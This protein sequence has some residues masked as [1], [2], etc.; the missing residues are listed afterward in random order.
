[1]RI[2]GIHDG[3][4]AAAALVVDGRVVAAVQEER[5]TREKNWSGFPVQSIAW[6]L[7][8]AGLEARELDAVAMNGTHMPYPKDRDALLEEYRTTGTVATRI[9]RIARR[10][11]LGDVYRR[12][13]RA[14]RL[15]RVVDLHVPRERVHFVD[16]HTAHAAAAYYGY[17]V[18][19]EP[20]LVLTNDG[21]GDGLCASVRMG[22]GGHLQGAMATVPEADSIGNVFAVIT[23][24]MGMVPLEHEYKLMG[25]A[26]YAPD[27]GRDAV[28]A[29]L[30]PLM[31]FPA[32]NGLTWSRTN[33]CPETY[34]SYDFFRRRLAR[35]RFDWICA[36]LQTW[37]E[38]MLVQW[39]SNCARE[40]G[41][42]RLAM[43]GGV[44]M[45]VKA[46]KTISE[47][48]EIESL[49]VF[50]S[51]GDETNA[52][53]AAYW[54]EA[55]GGTDGSHIPPLRDVYW[56]PDFESAEIEEALSRRRQRLES[57]K[58][59][60]SDETVAD[61]LA[62]GEVVARCAGR[63]EFGARALGNRSIL[64]DASRIEVVRVINDMIKSRDFWMP[65]AP[66]ILA[67]RASD[68]FINPKN[69]SAPYMI[70]SFDATNRAG[71]LRAAVHPY[72][73]TMRPQVVSEEWNREFFHLLKAFEA[74]TGRGG[75]LN[76]SF[77]LHGFPI[78]NSADDALDVL[79]KSGLEFLV[80]G[81]WLVSKRRNS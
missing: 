51:C 74:R 32:T 67:D 49:F 44:F 22:K 75:L 28:L 7:R 35:K 5:F 2:L 50:P 48:P 77:N 68:Y 36:G 71:D 72:D 18:Y 16:H 54:V 40:T 31:R 69:L 73:L 42:R 53:G 70:L 17:G 6:V 58:M 45:N 11:T 78:V 33:G 66:A 61:L 19:D 8:H 64:A 34:Y 52:I 23:F 12:T 39:V 13:R 1:M 38:K 29:E 21:A 30:Q 56:G 76:T 41:I 46:N 10:T 62:R 59:A 47:L 43:S 20:V 4:N 60:D 14:Q 81:E 55:R 9:R 37:T 26:P 27:S 80:L 25:L 57:R 63:A 65:F 3:H 24:M 79:E 15:A